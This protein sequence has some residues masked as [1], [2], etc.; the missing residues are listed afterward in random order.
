MPKVI[1]TVQY[2]VIPEKREDYVSSIQELKSLI[3]PEGLVSYEIYGIKGKANS[4]Q[5]IFV[6]GSEES[7]ENFDDAENERVNVLISK[8]ETLKVHNTTRYSTLLE[9]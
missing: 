8:I 2:D 5:E 9:V 1:F 6:F 4:F 7:Y 3:K